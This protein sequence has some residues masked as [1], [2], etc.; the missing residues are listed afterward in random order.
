MKDGVLKHT[1]RNIGAEK[2]RELRKARRESQSKFW[3]RFGVTQSRGSRF[4]QGLELPVSVAIL[5]KLYLDGKVSDGDLWRARRGPDVAKQ[6]SI[7]N[8]VSPN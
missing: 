2:I 1:Q 6:A 3:K 8:R 7:F 5:V 4:E